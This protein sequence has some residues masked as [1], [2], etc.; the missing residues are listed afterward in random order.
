MADEGGLFVELTGLC[1]HRFGHG[2]AHGGGVL[3]G[4]ES[5]ICILFHEA[6][7]DEAHSEHKE[8]HMVTTLSG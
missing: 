3:Q 8:S 2:V 1:E 4:H 5:F 7:F 6:A